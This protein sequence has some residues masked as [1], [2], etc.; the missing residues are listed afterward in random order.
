MRMR[1]ALR[2]AR[3]DEPSLRYWLTTTN[4]AEVELRTI[5][6]A[7]AN[8][9]S[10]KRKAL[11][12]LV[13]NNPRWRNASHIMIDPQGDQD[14]RL[15]IERL[16]MA[17]FIVDKGR[18]FTAVKVLG[19]EVA[20]EALGK[21]IELIIPLKKLSS[22]APVALDL[23]SPSHEVNYGIPGNGMKYGNAVKPTKTIN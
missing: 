23:N 18:L 11:A 9:P 6:L 14:I 20:A 4:P 16:T 19:S 3:R 15:R 5:I 17:P 7:R 22:R 12:L 8:K 10:G 21:N 2:Q 1:S 13:A